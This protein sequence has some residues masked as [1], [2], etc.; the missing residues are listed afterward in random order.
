MVKKVKPRRKKGC[1]EFGCFGLYTATG[2]GLF[3]RFSELREARKHLNDNRY[4]KFNTW[5]E[6]ADFV[7]KGIRSWSYTTINKD[8]L[9]ARINWYFVLDLLNQ[10][11]PGYI[12]FT[13]FS[14]ERTYWDYQNGKIGETLILAPKAQR[15]AQRNEQLAEQSFWEEV[16]CP[17]K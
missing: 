1:E 14:E 15:A 3:D 4:Q 16:D 5:E 9:F 12:I 7:A 10:E 13:R 2:G 17:Y 8:I 11:T 6:A